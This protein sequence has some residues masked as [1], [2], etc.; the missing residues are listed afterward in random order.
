MQNDG[1]YGL[2]DIELFMKDDEILLNEINYRNSGDVYMGIKQGFFYPVIW[3]NDV[4]N[5]SNKAKPYRPS[6]PT[7][8][9]TELCDFRNIFKGKISFFR[10]FADFIKAKDYA[11]LSVYDPKP[12]LN[13]FFSVLYK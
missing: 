10:W 4:L 2:Y 13:K 7:Y 3:Y 8:A 5:I 9:M 1:F 11:I 12:F 6:Y